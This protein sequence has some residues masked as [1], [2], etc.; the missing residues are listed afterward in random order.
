MRILGCIYTHYGI[1]LSVRVDN[2]YS[3]VILTYHASEFV[4]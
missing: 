2:T 3:S 4:N 1:V